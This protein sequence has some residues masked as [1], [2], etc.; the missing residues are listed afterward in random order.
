MAVNSRWYGAS[1]TQN[2]PV[3]EHS[4]HVFRCA[5]SG[6]LANKSPYDGESIRKWT[7]VRH[8]CGLLPVMQQGRRQTVH[9][10]PH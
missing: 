6:A 7:C 4:S 2:V 5:L 9:S 8:L 3:W 10:T 1:G